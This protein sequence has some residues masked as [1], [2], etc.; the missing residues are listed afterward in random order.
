M[1]MQGTKQD[2]LYNLQGSTVIGSIFDVSQSG[3]HVSNDLFDN[4]LWHLSLG[5]MSEKWYRY[6]EQVRPTWKSQG[7][8]SSV[9]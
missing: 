8:I 3:S 1:V 2:N 5:H 9:L 4:S 6:F 7:G